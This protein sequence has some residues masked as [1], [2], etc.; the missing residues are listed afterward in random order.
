MVKMRARMMLGT[1]RLG[2]RV[3]RLEEDHACAGAV[4]AVT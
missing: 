1:L 4:G 3:I 2:W